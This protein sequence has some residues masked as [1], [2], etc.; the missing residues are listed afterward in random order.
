MVG[1]IK[2]RFLRKR[3]VCKI[4]KQLLAIRAMNKAVEVRLRENL[5]G[6]SVDSAIHST[7]SKRLEV[8]CL[9]ALLQ[10]DLLEKF[11]I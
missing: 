11:G 1:N 4:L 2:G 3:G 9:Q 6:G 10:K 7:A 5:I 8:T